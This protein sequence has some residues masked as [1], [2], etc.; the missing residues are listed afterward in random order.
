[1]EDKSYHVHFLER[2]VQN[3]HTAEEHDQFL[4]WYSHASP[5]QADEVLADYLLI[6][7]KY[8][9]AQLFPTDQ[10][11][12]ERLERR[13]D[14]VDGYRPDDERETRILE[15]SWLAR[16]AAAAVVILVGTGLFY[17]WTSYGTEKLVKGRIS[18]QTNDV[19]PGGDKAIL[20]LADGSQIALDDVRS[21]PIAHQVGSTIRKADDGQL[22]YALGEMEHKAGAT[23]K[24]IMNTITTPRAGQYK[25]V[26]PDGTRAWLNSLSSI[27]FPTVFL[28]AVRQ[29]EITGEVYFEVAKNSRQP[30]RV[31]VNNQMEVEVLGTHFNI[32]AYSDEASINTTLLEG[33][34]K[35]NANRSEQ[36][37][38]PGQQAQVRMGERG[39]QVVR[40]ADLEHIMAWKN[41]A[42]SFEDADLRSVM[43][44]L[45]R[46]Y[47]VEVS[48][49]GRIPAGEF[50]GKI[51]KN[52]TLGQVLKVLT[53]TR[54][55]YRI[56]NG[57]KIIIM[58]D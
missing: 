44:Q 13:L 53:V 6:S 50:N 34:V 8:G 31:K 38:T 1:M 55:K 24:E 29:V 15:R 58:S 30:F 2:Y 42:F 21:G 40:K 51:S 26:L 18:P 27:R 9:S 36:V 41:G 46:W 20:T 57:S 48:Y 54:V 28:D 25:V 37:L 12:L 43:R 39:I 56:E 17:L 10:R 11:L 23:R 4:E 19:A 32:N 14:E 45:A 5:E 49:E 35:I 3:L 47:D 7:K 16:Y 22:I 52:L 33:A